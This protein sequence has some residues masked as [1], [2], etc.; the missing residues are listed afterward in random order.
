MTYLLRLQERPHTIWLRSS[1]DEAVKAAMTAMNRCGELRVQNMATAN[2]W[3][4]G[5][6]DEAELLKML[7]N[8]PC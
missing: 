5:S 8:R 7:D 4:S 2:T 1:D 6:V 3:V